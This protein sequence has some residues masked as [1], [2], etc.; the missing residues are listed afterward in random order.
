M[1]W[2][3]GAPPRGTT[4]APRGARQSGGRGRVALLATPQ[5]AWV[6]EA[7]LPVWSPCPLTSDLRPSCLRVTPRRRSRGVFINR[8]PGGSETPDRWI[9]TQ[10]NGA[11]AHAQVRLHSHMRTGARREWLSPPSAS[12]RTAG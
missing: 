7:V 10:G 12:L 5:P 6:V 9:Q 1:P 3:R 8:T 4:C 2:G 11:S